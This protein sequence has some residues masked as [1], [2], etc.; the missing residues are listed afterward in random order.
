MRKKRKKII[1]V[2][3]RR[4]VIRRRYKRFLGGLEKYLRTV[5]EKLE[6]KLKKEENNEYSLAE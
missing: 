2:A 5:K 6:E 3:P 4:E 1:K